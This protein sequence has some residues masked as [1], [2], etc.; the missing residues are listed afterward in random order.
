MAAWWINKAQGEEFC[1]TSQVEVGGL[2]SAKALSYVCAHRDELA[3]LLA[4][5]GAALRAVEAVVGRPPADDGSLTALLDAL[6]TA[7]RHA[8]D[9][10]GVYGGTG[11]SVMPTGVADL[12]VVYRCP[13]Q[14][15]I[16][17]S[18]YEVDDGVPRCQFASGETA[19]I[20]ERL[21]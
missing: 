17:R 20:R 6:H 1:M 4:E 7:V 10:S 9:P 3:A 12:E 8:G 16:G 5:D 13:L 19:L 18:G 14:L 15:C 11:R 21:P 2:R